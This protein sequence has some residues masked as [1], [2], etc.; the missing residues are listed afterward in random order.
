MKNVLLL[1]AWFDTPQSHWYPWLKAELEKKGYT[2][3]IPLLPTINTG[4]PQLSAAL[5]GLKRLKVL[6]EETIVIGHSIGCLIGMR[7]AEKYKFKKLILVAG[8]DF[9]DLQEE[10]LNFW[11]RKMNH[12]KI[13]NN[14]KEIV[15]ITSD[16]DPYT[17]AAVANEMSKRLGAEYVLVPGAGH[18][19]ES[20][21][22]GRKEFPEILDAI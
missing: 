22:G 3:N 6:N 8:W 16:N 2:V 13:K 10:H 11:K 4:A 5:K 20:T 14:V 7:L 18:F 15:V 21:S 17:T 1:H 19:T 9:D 12:E